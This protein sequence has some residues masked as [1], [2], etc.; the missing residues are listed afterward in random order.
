[1][2]KACAPVL[3]QVSASDA[4]EERLAYEWSV[5]GA[6]PDARYDLQTAGNVA[7]FMAETVA[8]YTLRVTVID[9]AGHET[10]L[11]FPIHVG[12]GD[13]GRCPARL[14]P[15][16]SDDDFAAV[17]ARAAELAELQAARIGARDAILSAPGALRISVAEPN[18][19]GRVG[20]VDE[21]AA[22]LAEEITAVP[23]AVISR[24][25]RTSTASSVKA[26][27]STTSSRHR[28]PARSPSPP[29][30]GR[31]T[32]S[33]TRSPSSPATRRRRW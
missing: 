28:G 26:R 10:A 12:E 9:E 33:P 15:V 17:A 27:R 14:Q 7:S 13:G 22:A 5:L 19:R 3:V 18:N 31:S 4:D 20:V 25:P 16:S 29:P 8:S 6:D 30:R 2:T 24:G 21:E 32:P 11:T 1:M 23:T